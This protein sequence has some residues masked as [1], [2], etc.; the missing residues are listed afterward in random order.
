MSRPAA[1]ND[2]KNSLSRGLFAATLAAL[3]GMFS[4][5]ITAA[6]A[7][8]LWS[9]VVHIEYANGTVYEHAF[10]TGV[11]TATLPSILEACGRAHAGG[12]AVRYHCYPVPE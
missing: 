4:V 11:P 5:G 6:S 7:A 8:P 10:A 3:I 12:S 2:V 9:V 1:W